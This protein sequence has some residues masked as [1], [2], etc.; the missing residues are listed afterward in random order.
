MRYN[1]KSGLG[2][3]IIMMLAGSVCLD[4]LGSRLSCVL[5]LHL[6]DNTFLPSLMSDMR[7]HRFPIHQWGLQEPFYL[8]PII[9]ISS[10]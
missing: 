10:F 8:P 9:P 1:V 5:L 3:Y 6:T 7:F 4:M 2:F